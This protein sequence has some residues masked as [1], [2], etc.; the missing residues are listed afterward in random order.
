MATI[1]VSKNEYSQLRRQAS[2]YRRLAGS[3]FESILRDPIED[4]AHDFRATNLYSDAFLDDLASG[5]RQSSYASYVKSH[6]HRA[7]SKRS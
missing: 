4:V 2:A 1:T 6:G 5:L 3:V 7:A